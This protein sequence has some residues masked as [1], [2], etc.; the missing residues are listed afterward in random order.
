MEAIF[1]FMGKSIAAALILWLYYFLLLRNTEFHQ[2]NRFYLL[3]AMPLSVALPWVQIHW[4]TIQPDNEVLLQFLRL[5]HQD[6]TAVTPVSNSSS[7]AASDWLL[8]GIFLIGAL[9]LIRFGY[10]I[11]QLYQLKRNSP[12]FKLEGFDLV[13]TNLT[14]APFT[15]FK[16]LFWNQALDWRTPTG[17]KILRHELAHIQKKHSIDRIISQIICA[18]YW[19]NPVLLLFK[20]ELNLIHEFQADA[21]S[22][23]KSDA[24]SLSEM[25]LYAHFGSQ[26]FQAASP[27]LS[28]NIKKRIKMIN[29]KHSTAFS[30]ARRLWV[31][32]VVA[33]LSFS[34]VVRAENNKVENLNNQLRDWQQYAQQP[35]FE[36]PPVNDSIR[37]ALAVQKAQL[38]AKQKALE[39]H[40]A[41]NQAQQ[42]SL[43][44]NSSQIEAEKKSIEAQKQLAETLAQMSDAQL[45]QAEVQKQLKSIAQQS[46]KVKE[47][48]TSQYSFTPIENSEQVVNALKQL[49]FKF[50]SDS[51]S[52]EKWHLSEKE[53]QKALKLLENLSINWQE[54]SNNT[55]EL[56]KIGD[57]LKF[58][59][60]KDSLILRQRTPNQNRTS[61]EQKTIILNSNQRTSP[62]QEYTATVRFYPDSEK[63]TNGKKQKKSEMNETLILLNGKPIPQEQMLKLSSSDIASVNVL[64]D[65]H[66]P[67]KYR[68]KYKSVIEIT[69]H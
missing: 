67:A 22:L 12:I 39:A 35:D 17:S 47:H 4:F 64:K 2:Y 24:K 32:P 11:F 27:F 7:L 14:S 10:G 3:L 41:A 55:L 65:K 68:K 38:E 34:F 5:M 30:Y 25:L 16:N 8:Y 42:L 29:K 23:E 20:K 43:Q 51:A 58:K 6:Y 66:I 15:F 44:A 50:Q 36:Q 49:A 53:L 48:I 28:S 26:N 59:I 33:A 61:K 13:Q 21:A 54:N 52:I 19:F 46:Q 9:L 37:R 63:S 62:D 40:I 57:S 18:V 45:Q 1:L 69:T 56:W 60:S 31:L